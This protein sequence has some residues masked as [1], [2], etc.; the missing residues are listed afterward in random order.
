MWC[1]ALVVFFHVI[2]PPVDDWTGFGVNALLPLRP[3]ML[4][5][6]AVGPGSGLGVVGVDP[7]PPLHLHIARAPATARVDPI[8]IR[9]LPLPPLELREADREQNRRHN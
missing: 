3:T 6:T 5:V 1:I 2:M 8:N 9:I 7:P 4:M